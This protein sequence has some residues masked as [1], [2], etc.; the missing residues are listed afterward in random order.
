MKHTYQTVFKTTF[1]RKGWLLTFLIA[2]SLTGVKA[3]NT[4]VTLSENS[5]SSVFETIM[6]RIQTA[7]KA[8]AV[9]TIVNNTTYYMSVLQENGSFPDINYT[10]RSQT[11]WKPLGHIDRM[12]TLVLAY[13]MSNSRYY[14]DQNIY[15]MIV[16]MLNYWYDTNPTSTNWYN[17]QIACP[18]RI[19]VML[20]LMRSG[21]VQLPATLENKLIERMKSTGGRPD[22]S[23]SQGTGANKLDIAIH[24]IYRGCLTAD[25]SILTF[26]SQQAYMPLDLTTDEG[27]QHD[28]TY[29][30]HGNQL[31]IGGYGHV[32]VDGISNLATYLVGTPYAISG[33]KLEQLS[34]FLRKSYLPVIRGRHFLYNVNGRSIAKSNTLSQGGFGTVVNRMIVLDPE[35]EQTYRSAVER[36]S[37]RQN[38]GYGLQPMNSHFWRSDYTVHQRPGFTMDVRMSSRYACRNENGNNENLKGYFLTDGATDIAVN[39]EEYAEIFPVWDWTRIPG[40]TTPV[41]SSIPKPAQWGNLGTSTFA[42]GVSDGVY[43]VTTYLLN[44]NNYNINTTAKK[45][46]FFFDDEVV[47]LG[48]GIKSSASQQINTTVNQSLLKGDVTVNAGGTETTLDKGSR[49]YTNLLWVQHD[50]IGYY[51]PK[52]GNITLGNQEQTGSWQSITSAAS[53]TAITKDVFK[54]WFNHGTAPSNANYSYFIVPGKTLSEMRNYSPANIEILA[55]TDS[56]QVVRHKG[57]NIMGFVFYRAATYKDNNISLRA[58]KACTVLAKDINTSSVNIFI[59]D[60]SRSQQVITLYAGFPGI[61]NEKELRCVL[62]T[63][64][65]AYAGSSYH[66]VIQES[67]PNYNHPTYEY[68]TTSADAWIRDG[69]YA[70]TNYGSTNTLTVKKDGEGYNREV[71]IK[72]DLQNID[73][74]NFS[75]VLLNMYVSNANSSIH[76][77]QWSIGY[78]SNDNWEENTLTW[79]NKPATTNVITTVN[80]VSAGSRLIADITDAVFNEIR[81]NNKVLTLHITSTTRGN[82]GKTDAQFSSKENSDPGK[83][84]QLMFQHKTSV[85]EKHNYEVVVSEDAWIRDGDYANTNNGTGSTL[86]VKKDGEG[87]NRETYL[88]FNLENIELTS[89]KDVKLKM[90]VSNANSSIKSVLWN[91]IPV[92]NNWTETT[93]TWNNRP[94]NLSAEIATTYGK[95]A[96]SDMYIDLTE[97]IKALYENGNK[98]FSLR[99][100]GSLGSDG[101]TDAQFYS[102]E[103]SDISK[104]PKLLIETDSQTFG[105]SDDGWI[106]DGDYSND[107]YGSSSYLTVKKDNGTGYTREAIL[108]FDLGDTYYAAINNVKLRLNVA[109]ANTSIQNITWNVTPVANNWSESTLTWANKPSELGNVIASSQGTPAG[110]TVDFDITEH[111]RQQYENGNKVFSVHIS[112]TLS[113]D[114]KSD[115]QFY[116]KEFGDS[117][118]HP[119]LIVGGSTSLTTRSATNNYIDLA[120]EKATG[121]VTVYP[122]PARMGEVVNINLQENFYKKE[123]R[124]I[125][126]NGKVIKT[127]NKDYIETSDLPAGLYIINI[128]DKEN[129]NMN[130]NT[131]LIIK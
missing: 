97:Y 117:S 40:T 124:V 68:L 10:D 25:A 118:K 66:Y 82:D 96:G 6:S 18:Q 104:R 39:G 74:N 89:I 62:A 86:V 59:A 43:G 60:P 69:S 129:N 20:I 80:T 64:P 121:K 92:A 29:H 95:P 99:I 37:G 26:A 17:Q 102:K 94:S 4:S 127:T 58:D 5:S 7:H 83:A 105:A 72:F 71:Y 93:L 3:N 88:K 103:N 107:N 48:A 77:T 27:L 87:Y 38:A 130:F 55:N 113:T 46:W 12:K 32:I 23:G 90:S 13:T 114:G 35:H 116:S 131:K 111:V 9:N 126:I 2:I 19:G 125:D 34:N 81:N 63:H 22:Q 56:V 76:D 91:I 85:I 45:A 100:T 16:K 41:M 108:K 106:R 122:N 128:T 47:C 78:V 120:K 14:G 65:N 50:N 28:F 52:G 57:L 119:V 70:N 11:N 49:S 1:Y 112:G 33:T 44:D 30:Q 73:I 53:S 36:L 31:Y 67:T 110:S 75:N 21:N 115:A 109:Y 79:S 8:V 101:K 24:W 84:P 42:G 54:L 15:N 61:N 123:V 98:V 51:F